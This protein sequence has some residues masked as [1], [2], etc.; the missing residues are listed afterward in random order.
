MPRPSWPGLRFA[1][2]RGCRA[3]GIVTGSRR[4]ALGGGC[5]RCR[6][7]AR[8]RTNRNR[9]DARRLPIRR[10]LMVTVSCVAPGRAW[11]AAGLR[12]SRSIAVAAGSESEPLRACSA[13]RRFSILAGSIQPS[14]LS[15][16][17]ASSCRCHAPPAPRRS[18]GKCPNAGQPTCRS[19]GTAPSTAC[20]SAGTA[21]SRHVRSGCRLG[22][23]GAPASPAAGTPPPASAGRPRRASPSGADTMYSNTPGIQKKTD[24]S[25][26]NTCVTTFLLRD[27]IS[28]KVQTIRTNHVA[29]RYAPPRARRIWSALATIDS[30]SK[31]WLLW[32]EQ[33]AARGR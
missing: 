19:C 4:L 14:I 6:K 27:S 29:T 32:R 7:V 11:A 16:S 13:R 25:V 1:A 15:S 23:A 21:A 30:S 24:S 12:T 28:R 18:T 20:C 2:S 5:V 26:K 33:G 17:S 9:P 22:R 10:A 3:T 31:Q 8:I